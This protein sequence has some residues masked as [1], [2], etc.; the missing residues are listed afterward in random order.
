[1]LQP[2]ARSFSIAF[3]V[4]FCVAFSVAFSVASPLSCARTVASC[5][6]SRAH[7]VSTQTER[8]LNP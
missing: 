4:A 7:K 3:C 1:M 2:S 8:L 5:T 6:Q